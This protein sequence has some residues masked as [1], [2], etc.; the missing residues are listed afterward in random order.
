MAFSAASRGRSDGAAAAVTDTNG[1]ADRVD[2][3]AQSE[4]E[5]EPLHGIGSGGANERN[6]DGAAA[7]SGAKV[8]AAA[9][10]VAVV[11]RLLLMLEK[12][13]ASENVRNM[14]ATDFDDDLTGD[15]GGDAVEEEDDEHVDDV[16]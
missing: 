12:T 15:S 7:D 3:T 13:Q 4:T 11:A 16:D 9:E 6:V 5:R 8:G 10:A 1:N 14:D 2:G